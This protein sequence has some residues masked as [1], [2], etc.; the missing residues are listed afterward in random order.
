MKKTIAA[1]VSHAAIILAVII[2]MGTLSVIAAGVST[3]NE[4]FTGE[5]ERNV[6]LRIQL[7]RSGNGRTV[8]LRSRRRLSGERRSHEIC[9]RNAQAYSA[10]ARRKT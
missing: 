8:R 10:V 1:I 3:G 4:K 6:T 7:Y 9:G 5:L 2:V